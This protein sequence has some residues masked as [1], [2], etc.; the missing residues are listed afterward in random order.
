VLKHLSDDQKGRLIGMWTE[1]LGRLATYLEDLFKADNLDLD[2]MIVRRGNNS[3]AWNAA[4]GAW[5]KA[6]DQWF[7]LLYVLGLENIL[8]SYCPGKVM[9]LMAADVAYWHRLGGGDVDPATYVWQKLPF[10]W[11]VFQ[12]KTQCSRQTV[13]FV[14]DQAKIPSWVQ[15]PPKKIPTKFTPTPELVHGIAVSSP[16]LAT[17][18]RKAGWFSGKKAVTVDEV[19]EIERDENGFALGAKEAREV[20]QAV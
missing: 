9:R 12:H 20:N 19:V 2:K 17:T 6:R 10:P 15:P 5:N 18:L 13:D 16:F 1:E 8:D 3:S 4:A 11:E 14:C 7:A